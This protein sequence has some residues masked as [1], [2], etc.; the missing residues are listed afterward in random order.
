MLLFI[1]KRRLYGKG[2]EG[3]SSYHYFERKQLT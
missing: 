2:R 3:T 1:Y